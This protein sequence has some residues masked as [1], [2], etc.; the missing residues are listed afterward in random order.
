MIQPPKMPYPFFKNLAQNT[1][2]NEIFEITKTIVDMAIEVRNEVVALFDTIKDTY[3]IA[4]PPGFKPYDQTPPPGFPQELEDKM[5]ALI[6]KFKDSCDR[7]VTFSF[8][9]IESWR[10][11][12]REE[13]TRDEVRNLKVFNV[14]VTVSNIAQGNTKTDM[15]PAQVFKDMLLTGTTQT[16]LETSGQ[17]SLFQDDDLLPD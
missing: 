12:V 13:K 14:A 4:D 6:N 11:W 15:A 9:W 7:N 8:F 10:S 5:D 17:S 1:N 16:R 3:L 2:C